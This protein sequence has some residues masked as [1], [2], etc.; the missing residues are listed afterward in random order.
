MIFIVYYFLTVK[1][2]FQVEKHKDNLGAIMVTYPSTNGFFD[3]G[4]RYIY[5][6][7]RF[8]SKLLKWISK[9]SLVNLG[10]VQSAGLVISLCYAN[11]HIVFL[12][13]HQF[14]RNWD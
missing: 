4:I 11:E 10:K 12:S 7:I 9:F 8:L 6:T 13:N 14:D 2:L 1:V 5:Y 3:E